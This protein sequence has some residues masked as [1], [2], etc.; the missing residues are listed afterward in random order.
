MNLK[1]TTYAYL[2][3]L[4]LFAMHT[5][6]A[7]NFFGRH[8]LKLTSAFHNA[9]LIIAFKQSILKAST[10]NKRY[11]RK[12]VY[13]LECISNYICKMY[14]YEVYYIKTFTHIVYK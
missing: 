2:I 5:I 13:Q 8:L 1:E 14:L 9:Q 10:K 6:N 3:K 11:K 7:F 12:H 4:T